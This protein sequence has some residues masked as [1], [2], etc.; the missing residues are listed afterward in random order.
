VSLAWFDRRGHH[1][2]TF[3]AT[4]A[5]PSWATALVEL[6]KNGRARSL[7]VRKV[8]GSGIGEPTAAPFVS[9]LRDAGFADGYRGLTCRA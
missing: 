3:P 8:D 1:L 6:V 7:E 5:D 9:A 4:A 2:V